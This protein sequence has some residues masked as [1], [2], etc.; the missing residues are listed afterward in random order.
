MHPLTVTL[1]F[2]EF[3]E[4]F[5]C[6]GADRSPPIRV[7]GLL[8][9]IKSLAV[10]ATA[11]PEEGPSKVAWLIWNIDAAEVIPGGIS[12]GEG[13][14]PLRN[15]TGKNDFGGRNYRGPCPKKGETETYLFRVYAL[16]IDLHLSPE[17]TWEDLV[18]A[19]EGPMNQVGEAIAFSTG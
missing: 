15:V 16:D 4:E 9:N 14:S 8:S 10:L 3:P 5:T 2:D 17:S 13:G 1:G 6:K 11:T 18:R 12:D 19:T 7:D